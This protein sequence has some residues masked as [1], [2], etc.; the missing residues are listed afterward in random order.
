MSGKTFLVILVLLS[1]TFA[2]CSVKEAVA[3][4]QSYSSLLARVK[5]FD[6]SVDFAVLRLAYAGTPDYNPLDKYGGAQEAMFDALKNKQY[7]TALKHAQSILNKN[8]VDIDVHLVCKYIYGEMNNPEKRDFHQFVVKGLI[9][10]IFNS[11]DGK[12]LETAYLVINKDEQTIILA[13][14]GF[15]KKMQSVKSS[16]GHLYD[17]I[18]ALNPETGKTSLLYFNVDIPIKWLTNNM[19]K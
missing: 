5:N 14:L 17:V 8:Y 4:E 16:N 9:N 10:S 13:V 19:K 11:G 2:A 1:L 18:E 6:R 15:K 7:E 12:S 3:E